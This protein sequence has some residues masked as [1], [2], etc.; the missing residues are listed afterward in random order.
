MSKINCDAC[1]KGDDGFAGVGFFAKKADGGVLGA[2]VDRIPGSFFLDCAETLA[3]WSA[4]TFLKEIGLPKVIIE[5]DR[6]R[7]IYH[8]QEAL[9]N[10]SYV[11][12]ILEYFYI[13]GIFFEFVRFSFARTE[14]NKE[15]CHRLCNLITQLVKLERFKTK[16]FQLM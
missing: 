1:L 15:A 14:D 13:L 9:V 12:L 16:I 3:I 10:L 5:S 2:G 7:I 11:G 8:L 6:H 4:M